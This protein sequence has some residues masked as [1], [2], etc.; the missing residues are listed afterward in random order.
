MVA[1]FVMFMGL[2]IFAMFTGTVS[3]FMVER[4][5]VEDRQVD[6]EQLSNHV[7]ICGW[8]SK[9]R[10]II[11]ELRASA[12]AATTPIVVIASPRVDEVDRE[13]NVFWLEDDFTRVAALEKAGIQTASTC[14]VLSDTSA[15]RNEQDA[16]ARTILAALTVEKLNPA[17]YTCAELLNETYASHLQMGKVN[18]YVVSSEYGANL[19]AQAAMSRGLLGVYGELLTY[20]HGNE[21]QRVHVSDQ[22]AGRTFQEMLGEVKRSHDAILVAVVDSAGVLKV[23]PPEHTF[24]AGEEVIVITRDELNFRSG[25]NG[26]NGRK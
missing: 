13:R 14:I 6:C 8:S 2:T 26:R 3:A 19:L 22:W 17:V 15:G 11:A 1:V 20:R 23:N 10:I 16:D 24:A 5:R 7:V 12:Q 25:R 21:M 18:D 9:G 4:L